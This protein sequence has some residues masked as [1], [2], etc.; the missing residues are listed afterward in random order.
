MIVLGGFR[1]CIETDIFL[2]IFINFIFILSVGLE[3]Y[4]DVILLILLVLGFYSFCIVFL[5][6][7]FIGKR[8]R[9]TIFGL[10][11]FFVSMFKFYLIN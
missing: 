8:S 2:K 10:I 5:L 7:T 6:V 1:S 11:F 9:L 3:R 4:Y